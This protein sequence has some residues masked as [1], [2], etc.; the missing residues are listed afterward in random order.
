MGIFKAVLICLFLASCTNYGKSYD[1]KK[2]YSLEEACVQELLR[3]EAIN[4]GLIKVESY[5]ICELYLYADAC[6]CGQLWRREY[7][8]K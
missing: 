7:G 3:F 4:R 5:S 8:K 6:T 2:S 1:T